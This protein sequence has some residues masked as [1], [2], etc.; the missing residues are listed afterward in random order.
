[1]I[2]ALKE[3]KYFEGKDLKSETAKIKEQYWKEVEDQYISDVWFAGD[4]KFGRVK[5]DLF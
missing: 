4:K 2:T 3:A 5:D 1:L